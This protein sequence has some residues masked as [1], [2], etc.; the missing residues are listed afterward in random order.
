MDKKTLELFR[1]ELM[2]L[3][4]ITQ[5]CRQDMDAPDEQDLTATLEGDN[6]NNAGDLDEMVVV[7][8]LQTKY[9]GVTEEFRIVDLIALARM[10]ILPDK[11]DCAIW[12]I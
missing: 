8:R 5:D 10:A 7:L 1:A 3:T 6:F 4:D 12:E 9:G 2:R 11:K